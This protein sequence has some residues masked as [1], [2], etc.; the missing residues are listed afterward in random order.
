MEEQPL[1][2]ALEGIGMYIL[3]DKGEPF[4]TEDML[5]WAQW[6]EAADRTLASTNLGPYWVS[7]IF[8]GIDHGFSF[9]PDSPPVLWETMLFGPEQK[10]SELTGGTYRESLDTRR[11]AT[12]QEAKAGHQEIVRWV[13]ETMLPL[14]VV[15]GS[16]EQEA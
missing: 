4:K 7:T 6:W 5:L 9:H 14:K 2:A 12:R 10:V 13:K 15:G 16:H 11:Y 3:D 1:T 8:L